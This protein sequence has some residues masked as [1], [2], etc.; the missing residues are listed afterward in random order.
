MRRSGYLRSG[1]VANFPL[2]KLP[3]QTTPMRISAWA[4]DAATGLAYRLN[5]E[6][7]ISLPGE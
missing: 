5:G 2:K 7:M 1:W 6:A 4:L 3:P